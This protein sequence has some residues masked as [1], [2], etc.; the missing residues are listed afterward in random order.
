MAGDSKTVRVDTKDN[1]ADVLTKP[2]PQ[3]VFRNQ[4]RDLGT[5]LS[6]C[7]AQAA[8]HRGALKMSALEPSA[9]QMIFNE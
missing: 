2:L 1:L 3:D 7:S 6:E 9:A 8:E 4:I 5:C